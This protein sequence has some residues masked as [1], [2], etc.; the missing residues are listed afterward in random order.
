MGSFLVRTYLID[1][2]GQ[3]QGAILSGTGQ[4]R[5]PLIALGRLLA[6]LE[7]RRLGPRGISPLVTALSL[8]AY[9]RRFAP[10]RTG[11]DWVSSDPG[12]VDA[13]LADPLC[14][15]APTVSLFRDMLGAL[16]RLGRQQNLSSMDPDTPIYLFSGQKDPV[17]QM[18]RGVERVAAM[19]RRVGCREVEVRLYPGGRHEMFH[20]IQRE[21]VLCDT[22][23]WL[24]RHC[25]RSNRKE[26]E[27]HEQLV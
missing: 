21:T 23:D 7:C 8:G 12:E 24:N 11:A 6:G 18:G 26:R 4:E 10:N 15:F 13:Y 1:H 14:T 16:A 3:V 5:A 9:N 2:P 25:P 20:E 19:L 17:G 27:T 22:L